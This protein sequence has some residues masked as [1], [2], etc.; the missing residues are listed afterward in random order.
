MPKDESEIPADSANDGRVTDPHAGHI[1]AQ[2][3]EFRKQLLGM[4][5][6]NHLLNCSHGPGVQAQVRVVDELPDVVFERLEVGG[7]FTFLPLPEPRDRPDDED[8]DEFVEALARH[9]RE[10]ATYTAAVAQV[11]AQRDKDAGLERVE[12]EARD[13]V[14]LRLG[15]GEW[16]PEHGL[17][18]EDLCRRRGIEP[19]YELP[20]STREESEVRHHDAA[21][22]TLLTQEI[23]SAHLARLRD[24]ARSSISQTGV[25]TLFAAFGFLEWFESDDSDQAHLAP[26]VL[27]P[28]ELDR[29]LARGQYL[30][31][32][33]GTGESATA[34][35]TLAVYLRQSFGLELPT[36]DT[37]DSPESY[38]EKVAEICAHRRRWRVRRF[39]TIGLFVYS[40]LAIYRD[41]DWDVWSAEH[42]LVLHGNIRTLLAQSGVS[43]V[44]YA[45]NREIDADEWAAEAPILIYD[46]DSSQHSAI[47]DV[48]SGKNLTIFGPPGT[49]KSQTI[50]N[51][52]AA[53]TMAGKRVLFVAEKLTALEVVQDRLEK[54]GLGPF[55]FNLHAQGLKASA[56]RRSLGE[57]IS[58]PRP[59]FSPSRYEQQ[60]QAWTKQRD[61]L[62]T[63]ARVMGTT[64]GKFDETVHD[65]LWR[66]IDRKVSEASL[67]PA[68]SAAQLANVE[69]IAP[70]EVDETRS[71]IDRLAHAEA[72]FTELIETGGRLPCRGVQRANLSPVEVGASIQHVAVWEQELDH[73]QSLL[74]VNGLSGETMT[75]REVGF[76]HLGA[77]SVQHMSDA[78]RCCDLATLSR[79]ETRDGIGRAVA[80]ARRLRDIN[81]ELIDRFRI[82]VGELPEGDD[83][84]ELAGAAV[85]LGVSAQSANGARAEA[86][87]LRAQA[88]ERDRID[89]IVARLADCFG[90]ETTAQECLETMERAVDLL[91]GADAELLSSRTGSLMT[92]DTHRILDR[93]EVEWRELRQR[94]D[95]LAKRFD[96]TSLPSTE[97]L[98]RAVRALN[99]ARGPLLFDATAKRAMRL[100]RGLSLVPSKPSTGEAAND[101]RE[102]I[103]YCEKSARFAEDDEIKRCLDADWRGADSDFTPA[104]RVAEW[105]ADVLD[106]LAG[107]GDGR[108]KAR[109]I[110]LNGDIHR[111]DEIRR[112][113]AT[114]SSDWQKPGTEPTPS[115]AR[116]RAARLEGLAEDLKK[117]GLDDDEPFASAVHVAALIKEYQS[118]TVEADGD[119]NV[120]S[121]FP[122]PAPDFETLDM[123]HM[124]A[125][126][127]SAHDLSDGA[128]SQAAEFVA[129]ATDLQEAS[130]GLKET[131]ISVGVAW[132]ACVETL[133][134]DEA[135]FL[136]RGEH[137][138]TEIGALR[139]RAQEARDAQ[140]TLLAWSGYQRARRAVRQ[141]HGAPVL[142]ALDEHGMS[143]TKLRDAYE[144]ALFRSLASIV[145]RR[146]PELN[147][148]SSWQ[149][150]NHRAAF[151]DLEARLQELERGRIAY[152]LYSRSIE[153]GV[154]F[155]GP[156]AFTE[157]ALI[158]HQLTLQ[159]SSV[160]LRNLLRRAATALRQLKP[161]FMM[162]PMTV[163]EL[164]PRDSELF[165][166]VIIDEASQ[167]LPCDALGAIA[168]CRQAVIVGDPKQLPPSTYFQGGAAAAI[169]ND[170]DDEMLA[171]MVESILDLSLSAWHPPRYLQWHYRS[172]HSGLIQ[173]SNVRFYDNRLIVFPGPDEHR[174]G[175]GVLYH[176]V[177][178]GLAKGGLNRVEAERVVGAAC[179]FMEDPANRDL[180]LAIVAMNQ[181]QRDYINDIMDR[182]A[183]GKPAVARYRRRWRNTLY[184]FIVRNLE[185]V[186]GDER[187]V[188]FISTVYGRETAGGPVMRRFGPITH[189]GGERRLNVLF[190]R[191][192]QRMEVFSSMQ[193]NE[194]AVGP[195][196]SEGVRILRDYLEYA[197]TGKIESGMDTGREPE[198]PFEGYVL[199]RLQDRGLHVDPQVGVAGFRIDLGVRH[200]DYPHGYLLGVECDGKTYHS[201]LSVRDRDRLREAV[202][203]GLGWDIYRIWSTDWFQDADRELNKLMEYIAGRIEAFRAGSAAENGERIL[204]GEVVAQSAGDLAGSSEPRD[205]PEEVDDE[206]PYVDVGDT[207]SYHETGHEQRAR[208]VTIV[209][210]MDD[211]ANAIIND[212]KPLAIALLGAEIGE[213]VT[214]RQPTSELEV[215]VDRIERAESEV[216]Y[217]RASRA[218]T[219][220]DGV[221][222]A[223]YA[224]WRGRAGDPR[225]ASLNEVAETL[226]AIVDAEGP[227]LESRA[228]QTYVR[229][230]GM[231]RLG[232]QIRRVLNRALARLERGKRVVVERA[233]R[234]GG[235]RNAMLRTADTAP[236]KMREIG[237]R[238]FEEV[239]HSELA[240]L[241]RAVRALKPDGHPDETYREVLGIYG[242]VRMTA[243]VKK[244]F[245]EAEKS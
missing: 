45:I 188:I 143:A 117:T 84:H 72:E 200:P 218:S 175:S 90:F 50:A 94:R 142:A 101:L 120:A 58:M 135:I 139:E 161:C 97:E 206:V 113:A 39:L 76:V 75:I 214:V 216:G 91:R 169:G 194:I 10:S 7:E 129:S 136:D 69:E 30:Y 18:P 125:E 242:L 204:L 119:R 208:R 232:P 46:A 121:V 44:P 22:Q 83:L 47:A 42:G 158:Q 87:L 27:V 107:E 79:K 180:S 53:A 71:C 217:P 133:E 32:F 155:G 150:G 235:Y 93:A 128:W 48:L 244:R 19:G 224:E 168:R 231:Q 2:I 29:Q 92:H 195:G 196:V 81:N 166:I 149:L 11:S 227:V 230:S 6:R 41:L 138:T 209:R 95:D 148:L 70:A 52:I 60:K 153:N 62:R 5:L 4:T 24:R 37:D 145:Y 12:R 31:R 104:R 51:A 110:L 66:T 89:G 109:E 65:V 190:S 241:V 160:T 114:L 233:A 192:R 1:Q 181:R 16:E 8:S 210:G 40:K 197:A 147:E 178:D 123:V 237:P 100:R 207:V 234:E 9:K 85:S 33:R 137:E 17:S 38:F 99:A 131:L 15:I 225:T 156:R 77:E 245:V 223:P 59:D 106:K 23:L 80:R 61:G 54:A 198:S 173:F 211:P 25:A 213:A 126:T 35:V 26:L 176:H 184:P 102:L 118:L 239:P 189:A 141:S 185:T 112:V 226:W 222:L 228:Y 221:D 165:D 215:V 78:L 122:S 162:S 205:S 193:A 130:S 103:E 171:P 14:R 199:K 132:R 219:S 98:R 167:M 177:A 20:A 159:R 88:H 146:H 220:V 203:R 115:E 56:V 187:D 154:S 108:S 140:E 127:M 86:R 49:G 174:E 164:L 55:C 124:L 34:N 191:A 21:L 111:L 43:D 163:A 229:A 212:N 183:A 28:G 202:L 157:K 63:Y 82:G 64:V 201:A 170:D 3:E 74:C 182:E 13:H 238:S 134:L 144:W 57:R 243:Q 68:V 179:D 105:A 186:Q 116:E 236:V 96:L 152:E 67:P 240:A 172:R 36:F 73:L 151:Q